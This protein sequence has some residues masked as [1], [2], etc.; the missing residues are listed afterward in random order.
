M[1]RK[2]LSFIGYPLYDISDD[3]IVYSLNYRGHGKEHPMRPHKDTKGYYQV[4][5]RNEYGKSSFVVHRLVAMAFIPNPNNYPQVNHKDENKINNKVENLEWCTNKYNCAYGTRVSRMSG[6]LKGM[7]KPHF[8]KA[9][10]QLDL[11]GNHI[12]YFVSVSDAQRKTNAKHVSRVCCNKPRYYTSGGYKWR[13]IDADV[14][15][16]INKIG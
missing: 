15:A 10:E 12:A 1:A 13:F 3:G 2:N 8:E 7:R 14:G 16:E 6:K 9:V 4:E 5:L 11:K